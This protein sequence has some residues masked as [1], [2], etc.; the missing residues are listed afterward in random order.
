MMH[1]IFLLLILVRK[2]AE[3]L[4]K[5]EGVLYISDGISASAE[6]ERVRSCLC[7]LTS[8]STIRC[9][10]SH[11]YY[12]ILFTLSILVRTYSPL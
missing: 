3:R 7:D 8:S 5:W 12:N 4:R 2:F 1:Y 10:S 11:H 9:L 6:S